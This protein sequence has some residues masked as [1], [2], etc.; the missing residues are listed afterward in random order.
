[1]KT[2]STF[3]ILLAGLMFL[4]ACRTSE[5]RHSDEDYRAAEDLTSRNVTDISV[6]PIDLGPAVNGETAVDHQMP[7][8][9]MRKMIRG[10][11]IENKNYAAPQESWIDD[12]LA[13]N[14]D[15]DSDALLNVSVLQWDTSSLERRGVIYATATFELKSPNGDSLLWHYTC[16]DYQLVVDAPHGGQ[17][18]RGNNV[19]AARLLAETA[20]SRLPRK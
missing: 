15:L 4:G 17:A 6:L 20:L 14:A 2:N 3:I 19:A 9:K 10:Y 1:M 16:T 7:A 11:L 18:I 8:T 5:V 13:T 12:Q